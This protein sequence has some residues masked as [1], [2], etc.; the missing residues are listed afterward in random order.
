MKRRLYLLSRQPERFNETVARLKADAFETKSAASLP[1]LE[2]MCR[3]TS[4]QA[5]ILDLD[6]TPADNRSLKQF[7]RR[8]P[9]P[10]LFAVSERRYHPDLQEAMQQCIYACLRYPIDPEELAILLVG[11]RDAES[12]S[13][14][15]SGRRPDT[16][17]GD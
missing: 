15:A 2:K 6:T 13:R 5:V 4:C 8:F 11:I 9:E 10:L 12:L 1:E 3:K 14:K 7:S 16:Q 17:N